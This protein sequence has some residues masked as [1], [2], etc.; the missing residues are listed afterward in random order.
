FL[1]VHLSLDLAVAGGRCRRVDNPPASGGL[2]AHPSGH[3]LGHVDVCQVGV[4]LPERGGLCAFRKLVFR[5]LVPK[6]EPRIGQ[7]ARRELF[8]VERSSCRPLGAF[9]PDTNGAGVGNEFSRWC[10]LARESVLGFVGR[11]VLV[12]VVARRLPAQ[13]AYSG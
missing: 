6:L 8:P 5:T 1:A 13:S 2:L 9:L 3:F 12:S 4:C 11:A 10:L 7:V